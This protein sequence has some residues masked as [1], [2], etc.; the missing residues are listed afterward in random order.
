MHY[1]QSTLQ[2][3]V[4][5]T[6]NKPNATERQFDDL[7]G[8]IYDSAV[9][10]NRWLAALGLL[11]QAMQTAS[12]VHLTHDLSRS[13]FRR[14]A[15]EDE[16]HLRLADVK[17]SL[18]S[19][20]VY[21][22]LPV[23]SGEVI[24]PLTIIPRAIFEP[25]P[26]YEMFWRPRRLHDVIRVT[27]DVSADGVVHTLNL[28]RDRDTGDFGPEQMALAARLLP[29]LRRAVLVRRQ[30]DG[31][32]L[33]GRSGLAALDML[34]QGFMLL[35]H[36][37]KLLH[38][39]AAAEKLLSVGEGLCARGG[40]L[41]AVQPATDTRLRE[42]IAAA[43]G[44]DALPPRGRALQ[45][46]RGDDAPALSVL[47]LPFRHDT[48]WGLPL[49]PAVLVIVADPAAADRIDIGHLTTWFGLTPS[50]AE[51]ANTLLAGQD[52]R[53]IATTR[54]RE[55]TTVR[56]QLARLMTKTGTHRQ[57]DLI[58]LLDRLPRATGKG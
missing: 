21:R 37:G 6:R 30:L 54:R 40:K 8:T 2:F 18:Q 15:V 46:P 47:L 58:R 17:S 22:T 49:A 38:A 13:V 5:M 7:I 27:I 9:D 44:T 42:A 32:D 23:R 26:T 53:A 33:L 28:F 45:L 39:N 1:L 56:T 57:S 51:L 20:I 16:P 48:C 12:T 24:R 10:S 35:R 31:T 41:T 3:A 36:D 11:K 50:E 29:H 43:S 52:L 55:I 4:V 19:S 25:T 34:P 14:V